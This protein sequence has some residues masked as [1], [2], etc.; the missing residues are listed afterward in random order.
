MKIIEIVDLV[1]NAD[2]YG[3]TETIEIAKGKNQ[4]AS[5]WKQFIRKIK[6]L[7]I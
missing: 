4:I 5:T 6:R 3:G 2:Y 1:R 7:K